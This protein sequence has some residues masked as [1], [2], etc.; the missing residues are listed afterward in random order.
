MSRKL[1][2]LMIII[3]FTFHFCERKPSPDTLL[4]IGKKSYTI[5]DFFEENVQSSFKELPANHRR[6]KVRDFAEEK[7]MLYDAYQ[8]KYHRKGA[9]QEKLEAFAKRQLI[10][11]YFDRIILDSVI[12]QEELHTIYRHYGTKI[13][14]QQILVKTDEKTNREAAYRQARDIYQKA[15]SGHNF[16]ELA[17]KYSDDKSSAK[18]GGDLG[19]FTWGKMA[20]PFQQK[21]FNLRIGE[22][23]E[24]VLTKFGYHIIKVTDRREGRKKRFKDEKENIK[25]LAINQHREELQSRSRQK[26]ESMKQDIALRMNMAVLQNFA[27]KYINTRK[28]LVHEKDQQISPD[29]V[30]EALSFEDT[31]ATTKNDTYTKAWILK[32]LRENPGI[33][34][35]IFGSAQNIARLI[36]NLVIT[37]TLEQAA[38]QW[39]AHKDPEYQASM[40]AYRDKVVLNKYK[41]DHIY[42]QV[43][44]SDSAARKFYEKYKTDLYMNKASSEVREIFVKDSSLARKLLKKA[45]EA[46]DFNALARE[47]TARYDERPKKGYLGFINADQYGDI[48]RLA[49][50]VPADSVYS[51]LIQS[52]SGYSII[53]VLDKKP[54]TPKDFEKI[55]RSVKSKLK[56]KQISQAKQEL[57]QKLKNKYNLKIYWDTINL[58]AKE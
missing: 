42:S 40:S 36:E 12:T 10:Q 54:A 31:L 26:I 15:Q 16:S 48:G 18:K 2:F 49:Q 28:K 39:G 30:I 35:H 53:K 57:L 41:Q 34:A 27:K 11:T 4:K 13:Q 52:G 33:P 23:S 37:A 55:K 20:D 17:K 8:K 5:L 25:R 14:A 3:A 46:A 58:T 56:Q 38:H 32:Q 43:D 21:A 44:I 19:Y 47:Y 45:E 29:I 6:N 7:L 24:P 50:K 51:D 9:V 1:L 22:I